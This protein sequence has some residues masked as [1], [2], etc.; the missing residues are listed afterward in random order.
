MQKPQQ[1]RDQE[2]RAARAEK[3]R[4]SRRRDRPYRA[5]RAEPMVCIFFLRREHP[6][7]T[8]AKLLQHIGDAIAPLAHVRNPH[9]FAAYQLQTSS[10]DE[11]LIRFEF[12]SALNAEALDTD[13][14]A[15]L[16][17]L[18]ETR[19]A[20]GGYLLQI[21][22]R[23]QA[24]RRTGKTISN[25]KRIVQHKMSRSH[26]AAVFPELNKRT[27]HPGDMPPSESEPAA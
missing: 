27:L 18:S 9:S 7:V 25:L 1:Q 10:A 22:T 16:Q 21:P 4:E 26:L 13:M 19:G 23:C 24:C 17:T 5:A 12:E 6:S 2:R 20:H 14:R 8:R 3:A 11:W 15:A